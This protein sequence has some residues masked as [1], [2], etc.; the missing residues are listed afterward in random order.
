MRA[1]WVYCILRDKSSE[2][3][4]YSLKT[5]TI[6]GLSRSQTYLYISELK[7]LGWVTA[8]KDYYKI[9]SLKKII[10]NL[11]LKGRAAVEIIPS[12][13][14]SFK[15]FDLHCFS[16]QV[17]SI[18]RMQRNITVQRLKSWKDAEISAFVDLE[19][20]NSGIL[21]S[22]E[23]FTESQ[24][25]HKEGQVALRVI[26][27][28]TG[29]SVAALQRRLQVLY[30]LNYIYREAEYLY[31]DSTATGEFLKEHYPNLIRYLSYLYDPNG[32]MMCGVRVADTLRVVRSWTKK[33]YNVPKYV[34]GKKRN[35]KC[36]GISPIPPSGTNKPVSSE[37]N[38]FSRNLTVDS[39]IDLKADEITVK[40][41]FASFSNN[42]QHL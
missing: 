24:F 2:D 3:G 13:L 14:K 12:C 36:S 41:D 22:I 35:T 28:Y 7:K 23:S 9:T 6:G 10:Q 38:P 33:R 17:E 39:S 15:K 31:F 20:S 8:N 1:L 21:H 26:A 34:L 4:G 16:A 42:T 37:S 27:K 11:G 19:H 5:P 18:V 40:S 30:S 29:R 25:M 32:S